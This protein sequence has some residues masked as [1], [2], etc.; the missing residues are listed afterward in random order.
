MNYEFGACGLHRMRN[1]LRLLLLIAG[2]LT[3]SLG[4]AQPEA[5]AGDRGAISK[6]RAFQSKS[7]SARSLARPKS[8]T[9]QRRRRA[10]GL[11]SRLRGLLRRI[12]R[13]YGRP[14]TVSSGC[15]SK[16]RNRRAGGARKSY[17]LRCMAADIKVAGISKSKL[18]RYVRGLPGRGGVGTYCRNSIVHIDVGPRRA[19]HQRCRRR[20]KS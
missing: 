5:N 19:W 7:T 6:H 13:H 16:A 11:N 10:S 2:V 8:N 15:R 9:K 18:L 12:E 3:V 17:H 14:V 4:V 20:K 1:C